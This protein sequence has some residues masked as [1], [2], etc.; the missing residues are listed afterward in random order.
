MTFLQQLA[1]GIEEWELWLIVAAWTTMP[2]VKYYS[3][4]QDK[5]LTEMQKKVDEELAK[6]LKEIKN[7]RNS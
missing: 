3:E 7:D 2:V 5:K 6:W 4:T 1:L